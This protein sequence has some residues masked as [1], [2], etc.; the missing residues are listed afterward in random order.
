MKKYYLPIAL[1]GLIAAS[2]G[3]TGTDSQKSVSEAQKENEK[4][5]GIKVSDNHRYFQTPD[6]KP[7]FWL[8]ETGWLAFNK[9]NREE[10]AD[11]LDVRKKQ[12]FNIIQIMGLHSLGVVNVYGDT[13]VFNKDVSQPIVTKGS[14]FSDSVAY[15]FWDHVDYTIKTAEDKGLYVAIVPNWG[16][17][18]KEG[19]TAAQAAAYAQ[20]LVNRY[21]KYPNIIWLNGGDIPGDQKREVW[22]ALGK[23]IHALDTVHLQTYHPRGRGQSSTLFHNEPWLDFNMI[24]SGHKDYAQDTMK[25]DPN[26]GEDNWKYINVDWNLSPAKPTVDGE[27]SYEEIPHGL[28]DTTNGYWFADDIRRFGYWSV[29]A[30]GAGYTYGHNSVM[31]FLKPGETK[32]AFHAKATWTDALTYPGAKQMIYI[33]NLMLSRP[34]FERIP[35]QSLVADQGERYDY[36][37]ATRGEKYAFLYTATG[38]AFKVNTG[39]LKGEKLVATWFN[40]RTGAETPAG[41]FDNKGVLEFKPEGEVKH[42]NDWVLI[43]DSK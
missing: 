1:A 8:G 33:K 30:G 40:P 23:T 14:D 9:L 26:Y 10:V 16:S 43:L 15:D 27:P 24:Q 25:K 28:H 36:I 19:V 5:W 2:C 22:D 38:R 39:I 31:Q 20:F 4:P 17:A 37:A 7:F 11:Y 13:A 12:G 41:E 34:Y 42:G 21:G 18:A 6:G 29:F 32:R 3:T 35:D